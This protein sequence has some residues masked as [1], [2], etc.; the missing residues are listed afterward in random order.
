MYHARHIALV[1]ALDRNNISAVALCDNS[2][3]QVLGIRCRRYIMVQCLAHVHILLSNLAAN[4]C[5]LGRC[6]IGNLLLA[7]NGAVDFFLQIAIAV[8]AR[9]HR[10]QRRMHAVVLLL[11]AVLAHL[12]GGVQQ[13][14]NVQQFA[15]GQNAAHLGAAERR[16]HLTNAAERRCA[17]GREQTL[18]VIGLRQQLLYILDVVQRAQIS[19]RLLCLSA[20]AFFCQLIENRIIFQ[21][22]Q[23]FFR[24]FT[25]FSCQ[26]S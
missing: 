25:H 21:Y 18:C 24:K 11:V 1:L 26:N 7:D 22:F 2:L 3:L 10:I 13:R 5:Q 16:R 4:V 17:A 8:D 6:R 14:C 12:I 20:D 19:C 23:T 9:E 15:R